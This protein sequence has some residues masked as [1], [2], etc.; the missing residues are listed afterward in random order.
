MKDYLINRLKEPSTWRGLIV[1]ATTMGASI[2]PQLAEAIIIVGAGLFG[3]ID[4]V[5]KDAKSP[6]A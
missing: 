6:D 3:G 1:L 5:K 2:A 4:V